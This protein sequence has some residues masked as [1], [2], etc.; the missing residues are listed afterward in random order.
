MRN[1]FIGFFHIIIISIFLGCGYKAPPSYKKEK[2]KTTPEDIK[3]IDL[4]STLK[5]KIGVK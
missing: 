1:Y 5:V 4:N 2:P 3:I